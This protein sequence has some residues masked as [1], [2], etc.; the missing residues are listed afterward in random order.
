MEQGWDPDVKRF[1]IKILNTISIGLLW[2]MAAATAGLYFGLAIIEDRIRL[3]N[4]IFYAVSVITLGLLIRYFYRQ[5]GS[6]NEGGTNDA[7]GV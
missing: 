1:F 6:T 3:S 7:N 2:M 5:W 4:I